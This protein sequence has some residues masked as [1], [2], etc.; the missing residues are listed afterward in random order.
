MAYAK[1]AAGVFGPRDQEPAVEP[2]SPGFDSPDPFGI[3]RRYGFHDAPRHLA[4]Y[5]E[6][7]GH[8]E[9]RQRDPVD[10]HWREDPGRS[11][12][13]GA[14]NQGTRTEEGKTVIRISY[15]VYRISTRYKIRATRYE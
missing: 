12:P 4:L 6:R 2:G 10:H 5:R 1:K 15:L 8:R 9:A 11:R 3:C 7:A 14:A 13:R